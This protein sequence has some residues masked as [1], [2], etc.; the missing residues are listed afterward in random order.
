MTSDAVLFDIN[1]SDEVA[2]MP[3]GA[4][5]PQDVIEIARVL[6]AGFIYIELSEHRLFNVFGGIEWGDG[7]RYIVRATDDHHIALRAKRQRG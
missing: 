2:V 6:W 5:S 3:I 7:S 1:P 4:V